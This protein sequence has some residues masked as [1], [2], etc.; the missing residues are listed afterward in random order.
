MRL[1]HSKILAHCATRFWSYLGGLIKNRCQTWLSNSILNE[2]IIHMS[3][4]LSMDFL[5]SKFLL[6]YYKQTIHNFF[7]EITDVM[8]YGV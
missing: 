3:M 5:P 4:T 2:M 8:G 7:V 6:I 1:T